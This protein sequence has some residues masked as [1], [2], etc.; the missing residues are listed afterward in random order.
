MHWRE[1]RDALAECTGCKSGECTDGRVR[2]A[3]AGGTGWKPGECTDGRVR[4]ALAGRHKDALTGESGAHGPEVRRDGEYF[5]Q[6]LWCLSEDGGSCW[7]DQS[8]G[9]VWSGTS[10]SRQGL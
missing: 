7:E 1:V 9:Q 3:L 10:G 8:R 5:T 6:C 2:D 4:D